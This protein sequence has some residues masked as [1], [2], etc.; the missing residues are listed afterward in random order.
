MSYAP[1]VVMCCTITQGV[2]NAV[3]YDIPNCTATE[4]S[5]IVQSNLGTGPITTP[6]G[7]AQ[8]IS[9]HMLSAQHPLQ[10]TR[11]L[12]RSYTTYI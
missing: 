2:N 10:M 3:A 4:D 6:F 1:Q 9:L 8:T 7:R 12:S 5:K 11:V